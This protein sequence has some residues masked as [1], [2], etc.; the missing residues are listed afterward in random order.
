MTAIDDENPV[1]FLS[2]LL[3]LSAKYDLDLAADSYLSGLTSQIAVLA[4]AWAPDDD[5]HGRY[6]H[7]AHLRHFR[8]HPPGKAPCQV[9]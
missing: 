4:A 9:A 6:A 5:F 7:E 1:L 2:R 3:K 8:R